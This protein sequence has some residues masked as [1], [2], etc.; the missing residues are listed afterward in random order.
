MSRPHLLFLLIFVPVVASADKA[1]SHWRGPDQPVYVVTQNHYAEGFGPDGNTPKFG[2]LIAIEIYNPQ[3]RPATEDSVY[4]VGARIKLF[5][6]GQKSGEVRIKRVLP[7]QCDSSAAV[8]SAG[9]DVRLGKDEMA[10]A[11]NAQNIA[12]HSNSRREPSPGELDVA[13]ELAAKEF[14]KHGVQ[15]VAV[16]RIKPDHLVITKLDESGDDFMIGLLLLET[17]SAWHQVFLIARLDGSAANVEMARY[18]KTED[19]EDGTD[20]EG[21]RFVDQLDLDRD[22]IDEVVVE[23]TGYESEEF[24]IYKRVSG[25]WVQVHVGGAG[26]C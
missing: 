23:V 4:R 22:G 14:R 19:K 1:K 10:L 18:H 11:T 17:E 21:D 26:G 15:K 7:L 2:D 12:D 13:R 9:P 20:G 16:G 24:R 5:V 25:S 8:V 6:G 3:P